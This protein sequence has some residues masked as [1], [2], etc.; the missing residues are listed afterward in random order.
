MAKRIKTGGRQKGT[1]N[2]KTKTIKELLEQDFKGFNPVSEL[3]TL[4]KTDIETVQ[5]IM[6]LKEL[7]NYVYPKRR[8]IDSNFT[9]KEPMQINFCREYK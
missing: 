6:I 3:I 7:A 2:K 1:L 8:A 9:D 5:K 4:Y